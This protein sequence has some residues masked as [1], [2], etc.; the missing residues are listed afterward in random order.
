MPLLTLA[1]SD[2]ML[3]SPGRNGKRERL[4]AYTWDVGKGIMLH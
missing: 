1:L 3:I 4:N 2:E